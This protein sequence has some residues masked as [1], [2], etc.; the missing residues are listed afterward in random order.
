L[1]SAC[2]ISVTEYGPEVMAATFVLLEITN[3]TKVLE[4]ASCCQGN[5]QIMKVKN[6]SRMHS[7]RL[8]LWQVGHE[9]CVQCRIATCEYLKNW[10]LISCIGR[11]SR[12]CCLWWE[13]E[14]YNFRLMSPKAR[15]QVY[16]HPHSHVFVESG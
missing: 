6:T 4:H 1:L 13:Y 15:V 12:L 10:L 8:C 3:E 7:G 5:E 14:N 9:C 16:T 2:C 11:I